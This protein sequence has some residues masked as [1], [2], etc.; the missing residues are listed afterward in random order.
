[1]F[2][3]EL[4][5]CSSHLYFKRIPIKQQMLIPSL[6]YK[7]SIGGVVQWPLCPTRYKNVPCIRRSSVLWDKTNKNNSYCF[8]RSNTIFLLILRHLLILVFIK[9]K[10]N[11]RMVTKKAGRLE[12]VLVRHTT[13]HTW[14]FIALFD[15][16]LLNY[17]R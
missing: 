4:N 15:H 8:L 17:L 1:M 5:L 10:F 3:I 14:N 6:L 12:L 7:A 2:W 9:W 11:E 16:Y 13:Q